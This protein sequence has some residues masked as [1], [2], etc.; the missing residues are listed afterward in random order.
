[1]EELNTGKDNE[2]LDDVAEIWTVNEE[3]ENHGQI[4]PLSALQCKKLCPI[5]DCEGYVTE[6][7]ESESLVT[8]M[9]DSD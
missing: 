3:N 9:A 5:S 7:H 4:S 8:K 6:F 2:H 1:M